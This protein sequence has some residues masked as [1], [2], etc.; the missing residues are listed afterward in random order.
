MGEYHAVDF[1]FSPASRSFVLY[2][3]FTIDIV[4]KP[5]LS[6]LRDTMGVFVPDIRILLCVL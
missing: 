2:N 4:Q 6:S 3:G 5:Q 1:L